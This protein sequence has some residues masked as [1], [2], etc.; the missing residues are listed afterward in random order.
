[1]EQYVKVEPARGYPPRQVLN[2]HHFPNQCPNSFQ[3]K[4]PQQVSSKPIFI[5][6]NQ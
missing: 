4:F 1:M 6:S 3:P 2:I 5:W